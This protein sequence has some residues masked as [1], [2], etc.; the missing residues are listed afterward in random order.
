MKIFDEENNK[1]KPLFKITRKE[2]TE[3]IQTG[4]SYSFTQ[5][6]NKLWNKLRQKHPEINTPP[7]LSTRTISEIVY[8]LQDK[9]LLEMKEDPI[10]T[11]YQVYNH[12]NTRKTKGEIFTPQPVTELIIKTINPT[13]N[14]TI[15]EPAC[16][17]GSFIS[18]II[19][20]MENKY[21]LH[22]EKILR[23]LNTSVLGI[24]INPNLIEITKTYISIL[25]GGHWKN[26]FPANSL[27]P[28]H[29]LEKM[30]E[31]HGVHKNVIPEPE[32]FDIVLTNPP[33]GSK[34]KITD[35]EILE[36]YE[37]GYKW[38]YDK[39]KNKWI[40][41]PQILRQSV[42][43]V[44]FIERGIQLLKP[45][46]RMGVIVPDSVLSNPSYTYVRQW[47]LDNT[48]IVGV[49]SLPTETFTPYGTNI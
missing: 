24:D 6:I 4:H 49:I 41:T 10:N 42:P 22:D 39:N 1:N 7:Q 13:P 2:Y 25:G 18:Y 29:E 19:K 27:L 28:F 47:I 35:P 21:N 40:K 32:K 23:Y 48:R 20:Y 3:T 46:G 44:L 31:E 17:T 33:F 30:A 26:V 8:T 37:L 43:E 14:E 45:Y 34:I 36:Q 5:R 12:P 38:R 16:G 15:I 11:L 9:H